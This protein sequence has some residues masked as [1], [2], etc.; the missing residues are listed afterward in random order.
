MRGKFNFRVIRFPHL[1][2][3]K[4]VVCNPINALLMKISR[5]S[6]MFTMVMFQPNIEEASTTTTTLLNMFTG[7]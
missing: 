2:T 4:A 6:H 3:L 5:E 7:K 1:R